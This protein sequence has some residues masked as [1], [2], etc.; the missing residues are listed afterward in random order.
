MFEHP[1]LNDC[2]R[3]AAEHIQG[4]AKA[5][6][7]DSVALAFG[8]SAS[9][10]VVLVRPT[11][12]SLSTSLRIQDADK[13]TLLSLGGQGQ[14][15]LA[16]KWLVK[17]EQY[18]LAVLSKAL[19][20]LPLEQRE[21]EA[22]IR[23]KSLSC[24]FDNGGKLTKLEI[25]RSYARLENVPEIIE[26]TSLEDLES[27]I[28]PAFRMS[29]GGSVYVRCD[30]EKHV[31][32]GGQA[33]VSGCVDYAFTTEW[34]SVTKTQIGVSM[35]ERLQSGSVPQLGLNMT[36][37]PKAPQ[38]P[39]AASSL[40]DL[41]NEKASPTKERIQRLCE[42]CPAEVH[43]EEWI[44]SAVATFTTSGL[45]VTRIPGSNPQVSFLVEV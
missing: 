29:Y 42:R 35:T 34:P 9:K 7:A 36:M 11:S 21:K 37:K 4:W 39:V 5:I 41:G 38:I 18:R 44:H 23:S 2:L 14:I 28:K 43:L 33:S 26:R 3:E 32:A 13:Q 25:I 12:D 20:I 8:D 31:I 10:E 24:N 30:E 40:F 16:G 15:Q 19:L 27:V 6:Y 45:S 22:E 1:H 17:T